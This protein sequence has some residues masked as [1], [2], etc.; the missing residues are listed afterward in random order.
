MNWVVLALQGAALL[1]FCVAV[2]M[3][4]IGVVASRR[5]VDSREIVG[6]LWEVDFPSSKTLRQK[7]KPEWLPR[8]PDWFAPPQWLVEWV[9][10]KQDDTGRIVGMNA[11][12]LATWYAASAASVA[13]GIAVLNPGIIAV[14]VLLLGPSGILWGIAAT[15][16]LAALVVLA[17]RG[18]HSDLMEASKEWLDRLRLQLPYATDFLTLV[19]DAG[20]TLEDALLAVVAEGPDNELQ[21]ELREVLQQLRAG[22][23]REEAFSRFARRCPSREIERLFLV[24]VQAGKMGTPLVEVFR[25]QAEILRLER[26]QRAGEIADRMAIRAEFPLTGVVLAVLIILVAPFLASAIPMFRGMFH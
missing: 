3:L 13:V 15:L 21:R 18:A 26:I 14:L 4:S 20:G 6:F 12:E 1:V 25:E 11:R 8:T 24:V 22:A 9:A 7:G 23:T 16:L 2:G 17:F 5:D 10:R 19:L